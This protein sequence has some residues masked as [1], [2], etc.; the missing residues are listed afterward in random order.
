MLQS[1]CRI[2]KELGNKVN[3]SRNRINFLKSSIE[4]IRMEFAISVLN[5]CEI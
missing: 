1:K 3:E 4:Q 2:A 5:F